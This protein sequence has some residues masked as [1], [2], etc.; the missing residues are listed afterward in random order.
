VCT[1]NISC[2]SCKIL[3]TSYK[4][5]VL[6]FFFLVVHEKESLMALFEENN[7]TKQCFLYD[8]PKHK[9]CLGCFFSLLFLSAGS[10]VVGNDYNTHCP[11]AT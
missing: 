2:T 4:E 7:G 6:F 11:C 8:L 1:T 10:F 5:D 3:L 9:G